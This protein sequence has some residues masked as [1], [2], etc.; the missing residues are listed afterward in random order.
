MMKRDGVAVEKRDGRNLVVVDEHDSFSKVRARLERIAALDE[1]VGGERLDIDF[2]RRIL[3]S[4]QL[5]KIKKV[6]EPVTGVVHI[7]HGQSE[8]ILYKKAPVEGTRSAAAEAAAA[9]MGA[10]GPA[11]VC[12]AGPAVVATPAATPVPVPAAAPVGPIAPGAGSG[13]GVLENAFPSGP[14]PLF[15]IQ[16]GRARARAAPDREAEGPPPATETTAPPADDEAMILRRT[17]RSGQVIHYPGH[18]TIIG[19]VN[20]GGEVI[21]GG[22]IIVLGVLRGI[23]HAGAGGNDQAVVAAFRLRPTQLRIG[24]Y[25]A[26]APDEEAGVPET[27]EMA[28]VRNGAVVIEPYHGLGE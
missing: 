16:S 6:L 2:G 25:I 19:D 5:R 11:E 26:R 18:V 21:A 15:T 7:I 9:S 22:D 17:L 1:V 27:P 10:I 24:N 28:R 8:E 20:P 14:G 4:D 3:D 12:A 23:A 13:E